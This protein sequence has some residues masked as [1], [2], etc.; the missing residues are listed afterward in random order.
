MCAVFAYV[1]HSAIL[2][3]HVLSYG[4]HIF[5]S[6]FASLLLIW[7]THLIYKIKDSLATI[8]GLVSTFPYRN[9]QYR[10]NSYNLPTKIRTQSSIIT[11]PFV[12]QNIYR[13]LIYHRNNKDHLLNVTHTM[14]ILRYRLYAAVND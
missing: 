9:N 8:L 1:R 7:F 2:R 6:F 4:E 5:F 13:R 10:D 14:C 3:E 11:E 12:A